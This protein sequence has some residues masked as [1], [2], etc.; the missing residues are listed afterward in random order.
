MVDLVDAMIFL[1]AKTSHPAITTRK[2]ALMREIIPER[3]RQELYTYG[4]VIARHPLAI[5]WRSAG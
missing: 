1:A 2:P 5:C 3:D 4:E